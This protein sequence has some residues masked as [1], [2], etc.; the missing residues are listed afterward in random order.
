M[1]GA[2]TTIVIVTRNRCAELL[3]TLGRLAAL[4]PKP[5][6]VVVDNGST[7]AT[8]PAVCAAAGR[9]G[10]IRLIRLSRNEG[11]AARNVGVAA[12]D[13]PYVAFADDDSWWAADALPQA[14]TIFDEH[15]RVGLLAARTLVG[16]DE[17][18]DPVSER[19]ATSPLGQEQSLPG[20]SVLGFLACAAIV[21]RSAFLD[22]GGFSR[23]LHFGGEEELLAYDLA[24][25]GWQ[26]CYVDSL[27]AHHHPSLL[28]DD[29]L[30]RD[31][32][33]LR[34]HTLVTWLRRPAPVAVCSGIGLLR[35]ALR[36][37]PAVLAAAG[38][39]ARL[40]VVL[41]RRRRLPDEVERRIRQLDAAP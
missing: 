39:L 32:R 13:T 33:Q 37:P 17:H 4:H 3:H 29:R 30:S 8:A 25:A 18:G 38:A 20:P 7:D 34:N 5:S 11:A 2:R 1:S 10:G 16:P 28:R 19:M 9:L 27:R 26:L 22:A 36:Y 6:I 31:V 14:E 40:P 12:A 15:P 41:A 21:R 24:A 23:L 35:R